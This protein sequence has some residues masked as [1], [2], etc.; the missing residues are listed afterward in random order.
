MISHTHYKQTARYMLLHAFQP[1]NRSHYVIWNGVYLP[2]SEKLWSVAA[3]TM[4]GSLLMMIGFIGPI[5]D[6][7]P[8]HPSGPQWQSNNP[9]I[10]LAEGPA[11]IKILTKI[12]FCFCSPIAYCSVHSTHYHVRDERQQT[13]ARKACFTLWKHGVATMERL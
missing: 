7:W 4:C 6:P 10:Y 9:C 11:K 13:G 1:T 3:P 5:I 12:F 2:K 8:N